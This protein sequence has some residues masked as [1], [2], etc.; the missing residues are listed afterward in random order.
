MAPILEINN[1]YKNYGATEVLKDIN[2]SIDKGD[3]LVLV[4]PSGCG[5]STLLRLIAGLED[6]TSGQ[7]RIDGDDATRMPPAQRRPK[8]RTK[9]RR[10]R[11]TRSWPAWS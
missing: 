2:V 3:F 8:P 7:I 10:R 5:K 1:L 6:V 11:R 9:H 4:G